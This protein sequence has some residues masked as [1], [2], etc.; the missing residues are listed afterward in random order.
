MKQE[1][2]GQQTTVGE[3]VGGWVTMMVEDPDQ[4]AEWQA[5][6]LPNRAGKVPL[7]HMVSR[8]DVDPE[9]W[10]WAKRYAAALDVRIARFVGLVVEDRTEHLVTTVRSRR[11]RRRSTP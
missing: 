7:V 5:E 4:L 3:L 2:R 6:G 9:E 10:G 11:R 1:A 8:I